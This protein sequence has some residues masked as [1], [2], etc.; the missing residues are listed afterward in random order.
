[1]SDSPRTD[2]LDIDAPP[3]RPARKTG[4]FHPSLQLTGEHDLCPGCGEPIALRLLLECIEALN[5][6]ERSIGVIGIGCYTA[7][8][9]LIDVDLI[10]AL[11]AFCA[12]RRQH[13]GPDRP[14]PGHI[15]FFEPAYLP[16]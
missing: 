7:L 9:S 2:S 15:D 4:E 10:Q 12:I 5:L 14:I 13:S 8:T 3:T 11:L 1:M 16:P 6:A